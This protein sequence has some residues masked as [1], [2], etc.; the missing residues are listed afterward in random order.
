VDHCNRLA[1]LGA[2]CARAWAQ[3][4]VLAPRVRLLLRHTANP[5][6]IS[7]RIVTKRLESGETAA[8]V[9]LRLDNRGCSTAGNIGVSGC[10]TVIRI[11]EHGSPRGQSLTDA[12]FSVGPA[13]ESAR[14]GRRLSAYQSNRR[15]G[16]GRL[17][18]GC[19][20]GEPHLRRDQPPVAVERLVFSLSS[21]MGLTT[22]LTTIC[23][24]LPTYAEV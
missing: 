3:G 22:I 15:P 23:I 5:E 7:D 19:R 9:R 6:E 24:C 1:R 4:L 16:M 17:R 11:P 2:R 20:R 10:T 18:A 13:G 12:C 21:A 14:P 8:F